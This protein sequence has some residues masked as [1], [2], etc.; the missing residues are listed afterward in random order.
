MSHYSLA[1]SIPDS[2]VIAN[3]VADG[4]PAQLAVGSKILAQVLA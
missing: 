2:N 4:E 3:F 1:I